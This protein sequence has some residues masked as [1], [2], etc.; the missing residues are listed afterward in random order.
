MILEKLFSSKVRINLL[1]TFLLNPGVAFSA[2]E[3]TSR[4][5]THYSA[6]W[7]ELANL[8]LIGVITLHGNIGRQKRYI[9]NQDC[10]IITDLQS[11]FVK[12]VGV[13]D[14]LRPI[15]IDENR[16]AVAFIYG[17]TATGEFDILSDIDL[18]IIGNLELLDILPQVA[19]VEQIIGRS[20]NVTIFSRAEWLSAK[21]EKR[22]FVMNVIHSPKII[23]KGGPDDL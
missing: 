6:V 8:E 10:P 20:I 22:P 3:L 14:Q 23:L 1:A 12:T 7:K 19:S 13:G 5:S 17:S 15:V 4:H 18:M 16:I 11:I 2:W 9:L 21:E